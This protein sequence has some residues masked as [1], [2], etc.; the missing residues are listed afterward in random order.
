MA[1]RSSSF[2][3]YHYY[4]YLQFECGGSY[5]HSFETS[6]FLREAC[7]GF[8]RAGHKLAWYVYTPPPPSPEIRGKSSA[9]LPQNAKTVLKENINIQAILT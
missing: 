7:V 4:S 9:T 1:T 6:R 8:K 3:V 2:V 5:R